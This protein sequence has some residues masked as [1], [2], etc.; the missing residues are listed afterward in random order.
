MDNGNGREESGSD[1]DA[2]HANGH[3]PLLNGKT[4]NRKRTNKGH[5]SIDEGANKGPLR[6]SKH[7]FV[8][9]QLVWAK[10][11][12]FPWW[13]ALVRASFN[14]VLVYLLQSLVMTKKQALRTE[15]KDLTHIYKLI[16]Y[17]A[18]VFWLRGWGGPWFCKF[19]VAYPPV[20]YSWQVMDQRGTLEGKGGTPSS[21]TDL[22]V[23]F[24]GTYD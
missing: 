1:M 9:G 16:L 22:L 11:A 13:P 19:S 8:P 7:S 4:Y 5:D 23:R 12:R 24:F 21:D 17:Q 3:G 18:S 6:P 10:Y 20:K 15:T 2:G 14:L